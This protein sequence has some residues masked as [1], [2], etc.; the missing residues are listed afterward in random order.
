[1]C[2][3]GSA[4]FEANAAPAPQVVSAQKATLTISGT[5]KDSKGEPVIGA[6]VMEKGTN[7]GIVTDL[8]G[9]FTL[10]VTPGATITVS[11]LGYKTQTLK[12]APTMN[13]SLEEDNALL[14]EVVVV[15]F[16]TQKRANLTGAVATVD[17]S[18]AMDA[19]PVGDVT[20]ALQGAVPGLTITTGDGAINSAAS[21]KIR[22]TGTL[23]NG[24]SSSPLIVV[25]GVPTDDITFVNPDDI[26]EI[27]VLKD[28]ASSAV[29]GT[30]AA[31]GVVLITTKSGQKGDRVSV[32]YSNNFGWS[33]ATVLPDYGSVP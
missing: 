15:G 26:A 23:S 17:V 24:Q 11:Y 29:Y 13:V 4:G 31:F 10:K 8:D 2:L 9:K 3:L 5:V 30:R 22:G 32:K 1:M 33:S 21:I 14:D 18:K 6:N 27:S 20:K 16:G 28:A 25:D 12:A 7:R 19:R